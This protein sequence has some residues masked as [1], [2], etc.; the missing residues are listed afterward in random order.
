MLGGGTMM[1][2]FGALSNTSSGAIDLLEKHVE[3][4][5]KTLLSWAYWQF[6]SFRDLTTSGGS[7]E[8]FY[9]PDGK[10]QTNKLSVLVRP[11][12]QIIAGIPSNLSQ[13]KCYFR[14]QITIFF[15]IFIGKIKN[16]FYFRFQFFY[17]K[18]KI[19]QKILIDSNYFFKKK[20]E[21]KHQTIYKSFNVI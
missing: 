18:N 14:F 21:N 15:K 19:N 10:L 3:F 13:K 11:Y 20:F 2:E 1:T 12:A 8:G 5:D 16:E 9:G 4:A 6:K 7:D 17:I